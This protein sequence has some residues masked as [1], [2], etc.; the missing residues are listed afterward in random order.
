M[1]KYVHIHDIFEGGVGFELN[2]KSGLAWTKLRET[3]CSKSGDGTHP[4]EKL[5][6]TW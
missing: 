5:I 1:Y 3:E 2:L 6:P 4:A